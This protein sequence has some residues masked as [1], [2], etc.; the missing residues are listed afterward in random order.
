M[1]KIN[2]NSSEE[3]QNKRVERKFAITNSLDRYVFR[4]EYVGYTHIHNEQ[5]KV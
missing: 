4:A 1:D 2:E 5:S 3:I